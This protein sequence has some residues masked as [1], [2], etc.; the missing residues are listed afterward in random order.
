MATGVNGSL[1]KHENDVQRFYDEALQPLAEKLTFQLSRQPKSVPGD[2]MVLFLGNHSSGKSSFINYLIGAER[3]KTGLAP[4]D[5]GFTII[6]YGKQQ[7][8]M[9]GHA[10]VHHPELPFGR[11]EKLGPTFLAKLKLKT[12]PGQLLRSMSLIDSPG[13]IDDASPSGKGR[14]YDFSE[15]VREMAEMADL[16]LFFFDPHKPGTTGETV[17]IFNSQLSGLEHKLL[18]IVNKVDLFC[19][20]RDFARTYGA[21][22]WNLSKTMNTKDIPHIYNTYIPAFADARQS[23][24]LADFDQSREEVIAE[25]RRTPVRRVDNLVNDL[26]NEASQLSMMGRVVEGIGSYFRVL[27]LKQWGC[28]ALFAACII[29]SGI[30][31]WEKP[32]MGLF[33]T[34]LL[35]GAALSGCMALLFYVISRMKEKDLTANST[36]LNRFFES[37]Y[38]SELML[39]NR[40]D[41]RARWHLLRPQIAS[42]ITVKSVRHLPCGPLQRRRIKTLD[43]QIETDFIKLRR[44]LDSATPSEQE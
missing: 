11:L 30:L 6:S 18:I 37:A 8:E 9:D 21:L 1:D 5:D 15:A 28:T 33:I 36:H 27:K 34:G 4:T 17:E 32:E 24:P 40:A 35:V 7:D 16:I 41:L 13:M 39:K 42:T 23:I 10:V 26:I 22:C 31:Y 25:I 44:K 38:R 43:K 29:G 12:H 19:T 20:I 2:P 3:Q 14:G